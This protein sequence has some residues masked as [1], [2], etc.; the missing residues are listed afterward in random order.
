MRTPTLTYLCATT[1]LLTA[2]TSNWRGRGHRK[3]NLLPA[4]QTFNLFWLC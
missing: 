1:I 4:S 2:P 3:A